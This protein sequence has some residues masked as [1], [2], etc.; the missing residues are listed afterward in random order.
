MKTDG[1]GGERWQGREKPFKATN[2]LQDQRGNHSC[3]F[4]D[5]WIGGG[6]E[7]GIDGGVDVAMSGLVGLLIIKVGG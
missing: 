5:G 7:G 4:L 1:D 3:G 2:H 6:K